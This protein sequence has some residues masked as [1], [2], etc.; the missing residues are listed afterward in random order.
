MG[1]GYWFGDCISVTYSDIVTS[2]YTLGVIDLFSSST[3]NVPVT[4]STSNVWC[5]NWISYG[6][7][8]SY[9]PATITCEFAPNTGIFLN[10]TAYFMSIVPFGWNSTGFFVNIFINNNGYLYQ[11]TSANKLSINWSVAPPSG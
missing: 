10:N 4:G 8:L 1:W 5:G 7:T 3:F 6:V 11:T 9:I 2:G